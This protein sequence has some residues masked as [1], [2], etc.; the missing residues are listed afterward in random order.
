LRRRLLEAELDRADPHAQARGAPLRA[1]LDRLREA[2]AGEALDTLLLLA[3]GVIAARPEGAAAL[4]RGAVAAAEAPARA[5]ER[6]PRV[7]LPAAGDVS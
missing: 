7:A 6:E 4:L 1:E 2:G 3:D 5:L